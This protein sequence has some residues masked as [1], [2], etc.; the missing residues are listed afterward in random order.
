MKKTVL[1]TLVFI[2]FSYPALARHRHADHDG[3]PGVKSHFTCDMVRAYVA[4]IGMAQ[5]KAMAENAGLTESDKRRAMQCLEK[6]V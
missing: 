5:A 2:A 6:K 3:A 4:Q 1:L